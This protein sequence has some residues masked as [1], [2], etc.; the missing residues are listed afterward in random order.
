MTV[1]DSYFGGL[2]MKYATQLPCPCMVPS[3]T[4]S[5]LGHMSCFD[6]W[7]ISKKSPDEHCTLG[8]T[9]DG[10]LL[11]ALSCHVRS[12]TTLLERPHKKTM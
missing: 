1:V 5:R 6:Q 7:N 8:L 12:Q 9:L 11:A 10:W 4:N 3:H 2:P